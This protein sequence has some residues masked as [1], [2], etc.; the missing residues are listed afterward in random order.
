MLGAEGVHIKILDA[1]V[2]INVVKGAALTQRDEQYTIAV[3][4]NVRAA[5]EHRLLISKG[6]A[7]QPLKVLVRES[8]VA[9]V[10]WLPRGHNPE[11]RERDSH[12]RLFSMIG[13]LGMPLPHSTSH[14]FAPPP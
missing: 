10:G 7:G 6:D 8:R 4:R 5:I 14:G 9:T 3:Y 12:L 11:C 2:A 1:C 13:D